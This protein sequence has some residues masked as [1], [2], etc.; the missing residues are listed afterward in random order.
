[1]DFQNARHQ[2]H[3]ELLRR[4]GPGSGAKAT[5]F[6]N[7]GQL[8]GPSS[9][10]SGTTGGFVRWAGESGEAVNWR[11]AA[12][13]S[14]SRQAR[15]IPGTGSGALP[16]NWTPSASLQGAHAHRDRIRPGGRGEA[17][18]PRRDNRPAFA[19]TIP[20][21]HGR[22]V[23]APDSVC[24]APLSQTS[25]SST[26]PGRGEQGDGG[27]CPPQTCGVCSTPS[28]GGGHEASHLPPHGRRQS[29]RGSFARDSATALT[30][31]WISGL[32]K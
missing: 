27:V 24:S 14:G 12:F 20:C 32:S 19:H 13:E 18:R 4:K 1:M 28:R 2:L 17:F 8:P 23:G 15:V 16:R 9:P 11:Q 10:R 31:A 29:L 5:G 6:G 30:A 21:I 25:P 26:A 22:T 3:A 7:V